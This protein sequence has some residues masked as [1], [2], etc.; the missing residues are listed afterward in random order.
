MAERAR[1]VI[2][3]ASP[4]ER[5]RLAV[6]CDF[7]EE[8]WR[9]MDMVGDMVTE[10][11]RIQSAAAFSVTQV[12]PQFVSRATLISPLRRNWLAR[13]TDRLVNRFVDYPRWLRRNR[14]RFDVFHIVDHSYSQLVHELPADRTIVTCHDLDTFRCLIEPAREPRSLPFRMMIGRI[15]DGFRKASVVV[16]DSRTI[17]DEILLHRL[18]PEDRLVVIPIG[19]HP[20]CSEKSDPV[21]DAEAERLLGSKSSG[22]PFILHVGST[23]PR[24]RLDLLLRIFAAVR[25][26]AG[27]VRLVRVGGEFTTAQR[28]LAE[29]LG[30]LD[31]IA[32]MPFLSKEVLA[33]L[34]RRAA[35]VLVT[36]EREGF[37]LPV[38]EA[39]AC[40]T[41]VVASDLPALREVGGDAAVYLPVG[42]IES[43][44]D[45]V[46]SLL[47]ERAERP[48]Q[49]AVRR[50]AATRWASG[51]TWAECVRRLSVLYAELAANPGRRSQ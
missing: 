39:M 48:E 34:Y 17:R 16:C 1:T 15:L 29:E 36:S 10:H 6:V 20:A 7:A 44:A 41:P 21:A 42:E 13:S 28:R 23:V 26:G 45:M 18:V 25:R 22:L 3:E 12:R 2:E 51:F 8:N 5:I 38:I 9:A 49:W 4:A 27:Q 47:D 32:V 19:V 37:G 11:L 35:V 30:V 40:G 50:E 31:D 46:N 43:W 14:D 33:A 24:K